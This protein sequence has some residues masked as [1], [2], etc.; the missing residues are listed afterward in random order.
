MPKTILT[1]LIF[2]CT[3]QMHATVFDRVCAL[4]LLQSIDPFLEERGFPRHSW[5]NFPDPSYTR[6]FLRVW[7]ENP[8]GHP[9][10]S[11]RILARLTQE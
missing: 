7:D 2:D 11:R 10:L 3:L 6:P 5:A 4:E 9:D 1:A 8:G